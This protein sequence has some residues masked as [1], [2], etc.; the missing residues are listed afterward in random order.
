MGAFIINCSWGGSSYSKA[1][2]DIIEAATA[3]VICA[4]GNE[5]SSEDIDIFPN[6]P[7]SYAASN[8]I[9][10]AAVDK[11][12]NL[13]YFSNYGINFVDVAAPGALI[14]S[15]FPGS[16]YGYMQ[17]TSMATPYVSGLAGLIKSLHPELN[18]LQ[19][20]YTILNN[21]DP[22]SSLAGKILT[23]GVINA[24]NSL[25]NIIN[26]TTAPTVNVDPNDGAYYNYPLQI[27][28][29]ADKPSK[30][31]YTLNGA[32]PTTASD[33][34]VDSIIISTTK[35]LKFMAIDSSGTRSQVY[36]K[37]YLIYKLVNYSYQV[38]V[39]YRL[40]N[41]KYRIKYRA[42]YTVKKKIWYKVGKKW[43]YKWTYITKYKWKYKWDYR[44]GYRS[45][46]RFGQKWELT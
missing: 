3:L 12:D 40:S 30:I 13:C 14:Y 16:K 15:T 28:L 7:A 32:N 38:T 34:Y 33:L 42:P 39:Q 11:N 18:V 10:V 8:I 21:V 6:Y 44:Y 31:Y 36:K 17:G 41:K 43:R 23:G 37:N 46:T 45:E 1:L 5:I 20:K 24:F 26:D 25:N 19:V 35:T 2:K 4:A 9:T 22:V 27:S 29:N